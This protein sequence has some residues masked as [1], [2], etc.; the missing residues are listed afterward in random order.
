ME[1]MMIY[2]F[3]LAFLLTA[4]GQTSNSSLNSAESV[5]WHF[6]DK[7][8]KELTNIFVNPKH[9]TDLISSTKRETA[10]VGCQVVL[11]RRPLRTDATFIDQSA[12]IECDTGSE[13]WTFDMGTAQ[14]DWWGNNIQ[15][16]FQI[17]DDL[18]NKESNT[19]GTLF[20]LIRSSKRAT[21][22]E[23]VTDA[24]GNGLEMAD[25]Y[26][27]N[28]RVAVGCNRLTGEGNVTKQFCSYQ[29]FIDVPGCSN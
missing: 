29:Y 20:D 8:S 23:Y 16:C 18:S 14:I 12:R 4:C 28:E 6:T 2:G 22:E 21:S 10:N 13:R 7:A 1:T 17:S 15:K 27:T 5:N 19:A 9:D 25:V 26:A 3:L 24:Q 11:A